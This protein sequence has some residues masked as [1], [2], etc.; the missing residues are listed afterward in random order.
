MKIDTTNMSRRTALAGLAAGAVAAEP[1][2]APGADAASTN[3]DAELIALGQEL[4]AADAA[5]NHALRLDYARNPN[6][7]DGDDLSPIYQDRVDEI[8]DRIVAL[9]V[10][11]PA[12]LRVKARAAY[13][14]NY[15]DAWDYEEHEAD[16]GTLLIRQVI[17]FV[18]HGETKRATAEMST[19]REKLQRWA[20]LP[21]QLTPEEI[22]ALRQDAKEASEYC[23]K[24]FAHLRPKAG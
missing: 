24:A 21:E 18:L 23:C 10:H 6:L 14:E 16:V 1:I 15:G 19:R 12:G 8:I 4:D 11:T 20:A 2:A 5:W 22:E 13:L 9:P 17:D 3:P 7:P